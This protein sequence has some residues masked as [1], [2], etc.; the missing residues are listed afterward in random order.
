MTSLTLTPMAPLPFSEADQEALT[1]LYVHGTPDNTLRA[2][3][4]DPFYSVG[5]R[6]TI[7]GNDLLGAKD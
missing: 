4:P 1:D 6:E 5:W 3:E 7:V 2:Y